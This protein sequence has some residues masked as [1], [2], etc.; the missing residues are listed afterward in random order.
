MNM[1]L[2]GDTEERDTELPGPL[3]PVGAAGC[4]L[5]VEKPAIMRT[6]K[7]PAWV[8]AG[9]TGVKVGPGLSVWAPAP[10]NVMAAPACEGISHPPSA[11]AR[12]RTIARVL[13]FIVLVE[14]ATIVPATLKIND[15]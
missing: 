13:A 8:P 11:R 14:A 1:R 3:H 10:T 15:L 2:R 6:A 4:V 9:I 12:L 5:L 7:S